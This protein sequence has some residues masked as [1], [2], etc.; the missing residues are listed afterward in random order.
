MYIKPSKPSLF[1]PGCS[2]TS[3]LLK[4][5]GLARRH[6]L[7]KRVCSMAAHQNNTALFQP[8][9]FELLMTTLL[10]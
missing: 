9:A 6:E 7:E 8:L 2:F 5:S 1:G 3:A 10:G 4:L